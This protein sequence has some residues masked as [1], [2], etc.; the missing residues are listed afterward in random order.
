ML[1]VLTANRL[2]QGDVVYWTFAQGWVA[3]FADA[4]LL[5]QEQAEAAL[6]RA[7]QDVAARHVV[8]PYLLD[9]KNQNGR[10]VPVKTREVLRAAG[11]SVRTDLGKQGTGAA[12]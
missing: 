12:P 3:S 4:D 9:V 1:Q 5:V 7:A 2:I 10:T 6:K 11:P 8:N